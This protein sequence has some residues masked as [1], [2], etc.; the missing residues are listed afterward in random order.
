VGDFSSF[1]FQGLNVENFG[2]KPVYG[3]VIS[4]SFISAFGL[5]GDNLRY[6]CGRYQV[7]CSTANPA[8]NSAL[9]KFGYQKT[10]NYE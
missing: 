6:E 8:F 4:F 1:G 10:H 9:D 7:G 5:T 2:L 3:F